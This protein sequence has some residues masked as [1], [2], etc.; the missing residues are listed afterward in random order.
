MPC[1]R[2]QNAVIA[3]PFE[4]PARVAKPN[5]EYG[6]TARSMRAS[7][8]VYMIGNLAPIARAPGVFGRS[9]I[10]VTALHGIE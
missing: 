9:V 1:R 10:F 5:E 2:A 8:Y 3:E 6:G 7:E 4:I